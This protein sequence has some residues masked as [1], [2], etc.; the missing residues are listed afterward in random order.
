[1]SVNVKLR[2][3]EDLEKYFEGFP[4]AS[5]EAAKLAVNDAARYGARRGS[6]AI[7]REVAFSRT[8]IGDASNA[9]ARLRITRVA[10]GGDMEAVIGARSEPT[11]LARFASGTPTFG[12]RARG[13][14]VK[15]KTSGPSKTIK[16]GFFMKLKRGDGS[17]DGFNIGLAIRLKPGERVRNKAQMKSI[18]K[19]LYLLYGPSVD[20]VFSTVREEIADDIASHMQIEFLRQFTRLT[21]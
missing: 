20:Q 15:V 7:R 5:R 10:Q 16:G 21:A 4:A 17:G 6:E 2:G 12:R 19:G 13:P 8:Y 1:M 14:R 18:G 11:S 3:L 9:S